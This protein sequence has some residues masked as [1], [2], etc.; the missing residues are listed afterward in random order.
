M[1]LHLDMFVLAMEAYAQA[2]RAI[3]IQHIMAIMLRVQILMMM[4]MLPMVMVVTR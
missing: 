1:L 4:Y 2:P 3:L